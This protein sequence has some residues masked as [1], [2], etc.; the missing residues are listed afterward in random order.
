MEIEHEIFSVHGNAPAS[1]DSSRAVVSYKQKFISCLDYY[2][3]FILYASLCA[4]MWAEN[5][6]QRSC[7][8]VQSTG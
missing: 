7:I 4:P 3:F 2:I 1:T 8:L 6:K 5:L